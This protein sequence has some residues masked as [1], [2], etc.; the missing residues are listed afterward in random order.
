MSDEEFDSV[1]E[2]LKKPLPATFR[3]TRNTN[4]AKEVLG[5]FEVCWALD[6]TISG[7]MEASF[8]MRISRY[9]VNFRFSRISS[10]K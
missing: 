1:M 7:D 2:Y 5:K 10:W 6:L 9:A 4:I 3:I 8:I